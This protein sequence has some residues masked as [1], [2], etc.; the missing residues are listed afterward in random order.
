[1]RT[2][3]F[4]YIT[5]ID[6]LPSIIKSGIFSHERAEAEN[7]RKISMFKRKRDEKENIK[8]KSE[9]VPKVSEKN[10]L[11]Y[12]NLCFQPR[13]PMMY[14]AIFES[15]AEK[16][17][18]LEVDNTVLGES[19]VVITDGDATNE[20]TQFYLASEETKI[21]QQLRTI[22]KNEWWK[23]CDGSKRK[24]MAECLVP[25]RV[26]SEYVRSVIVADDGT[27]NWVPGLVDNLQLSAMRQPH[28][29]FQSQRRIEIGD[30]ILLVDGGDIFFSELQTLAV[31]VNLQG[32]MG[33]GLALRAREQF[34]DVYVEYEKACRTK[35]ITSARPYIYK[36]EAS[37]ADELT[38]LKPYRKQIK[39]PVKWFLLFATKRHWRTPSRLEDI[40][41]GLKWIQTNFR[42][43][44]I[45]SLAMPALGCSLGGLSWTEVAPLMCK[46]LHGIGIPIEIYLPREHPIE[47]QYLTES[48]LLKDH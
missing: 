48:H 8:R 13:N 11:H 14:R 26:K 12:A 20:T 43:A 33:K 40:E 35:K 30:N 2:K 7:V 15:S 21:S 17:A 34:S 47:A 23:E 6:S 38:D 39:N 10:L 22:I 19:G 25:D 1:M 32:V 27:K 28:L 37:V 9:T 24:I 5:H 31:T 46:Y 29:F 18:V 4:Y 42:A 44:K 41:S 45:Q 16:L 3:S 36:R